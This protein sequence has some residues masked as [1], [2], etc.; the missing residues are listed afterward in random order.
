MKQ[1]LI[2]IGAGG[3]GKVVYDAVK[4]QSIYTI[5]GFADLNLPVGS[6]VID[7]ASV[8][9]HQNDL[10]SLKDN[11]DCFIVAIGNNNIRL[12]L[13]NKMA[14]VFKPATIIHSSAVLG[15]NVVIGEGTVVLANTLLNT[16]CKVGKNSIIN[17]GTIV[18]H[19]AVIGDHVYLKLG[20]IVCNDVHVQDFTTSLP[21]EVISGSK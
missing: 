11:I 16:N 3:H 7:N 13:F 2:I 20:T 17:S 8:I 9:C 21:G 5:A 10:L 4:S 19:D 12:E 15:T 1:S 14:S 6:V 18:D